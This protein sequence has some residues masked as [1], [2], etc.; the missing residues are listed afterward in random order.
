M[1]EGVGPESKAAGTEIKQTEMNSLLTPRKPP[2]HSKIIPHPRS[3]VFSYS[4]T[5]FNYYYDND[6]Y[7]GVDAFAFLR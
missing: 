1:V 7:Y 6:T 2:Q 5:R 4:F 3:N